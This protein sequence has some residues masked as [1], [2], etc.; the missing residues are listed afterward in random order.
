[1]PEVDWNAKMQATVGAIFGQMGAAMQAKEEARVKDTTPSKP[2]EELAG[3]YSAP[4]FGTLNL[5]VVNGMLMG[6]LN[7]YQAMFNH[8][9]YDTFD[10]ILPLMGVNL[11]AVFQYDEAGNVVGI[12]VVVEPTVAPV[13]FAK[14]K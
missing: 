14:E 3:T 1:M 6:T 8:Y 2:L 11:P 9:H 4:A 7:E 12:S 10:F 13:L 5:Q